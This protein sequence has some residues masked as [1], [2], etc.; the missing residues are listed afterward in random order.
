M[1]TDIFN[2]SLWLPTAAVEIFH[3]N[4]RLGEI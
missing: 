2:D 1:N 3:E 4:V